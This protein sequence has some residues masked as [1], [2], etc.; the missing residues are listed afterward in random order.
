MLTAN[1]QYVKITQRPTKNRSVLQIQNNSQLSPNLQCDET[2]KYYYLT[3]FTAYFLHASQSTARMLSPPLVAY[4]VSERRKEFNKQSSR[5]SQET[6][7][8]RNSTCAL[9]VHIYKYSSLA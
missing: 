8:Y 3:P 6:F 1:N 4:L 7:V 9:H 2:Q 5:H